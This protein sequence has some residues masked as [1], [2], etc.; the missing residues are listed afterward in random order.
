[1]VILHTFHQNTNS[2]KSIKS[3]P[4]QI[5]MKQNVHKHQTQTFPRISPFGIGPFN[6]AH[7]ARTHRYRGLFRRLIN[8]S[9]KKKERKKV[10]RYG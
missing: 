1:M 10:E 5:Y 9:L 2:L 8:T 3:A 6:T 7:K 4:M